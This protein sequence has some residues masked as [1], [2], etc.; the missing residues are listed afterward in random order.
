MNII[1][2]ASALQLLIV[3]LLVI[4]HCDFYWNKQIILLTNNELTTKPS[5]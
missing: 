2:S 3:L 1:F 4:I 5:P